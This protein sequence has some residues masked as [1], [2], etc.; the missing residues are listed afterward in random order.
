MSRDVTVLSSRDEFVATVAVAA[1]NV[2]A[3]AIAGLG[4]AHVA[5]TGGTIG[6]AVLTALGHNSD[7]DWRKVHFWWGDERFV[8]ASSLERNAVQARDAL[9]SRLNL[10]ESQIHEIPASDS[11]L[12]LDNAA[13]AYAE[14]LAHY[15]V[16]GQAL[17]DF[18]LTFLGIGPDSHVASLFPDHVDALKP[19]I[20]VPVRNSPKP[21]SERV[22]LTFNAINSS[23]RVWVVAFGA[24][25]AEA[26]A[27][28]FAGEGNLSAPS[29]CVHGTHETRLW[30]DMA[31]ASALSA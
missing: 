7:V 2:I 28:M 1:E 8:E 10:D 19:G 4:V 26:V 14:T 16:P 6:V 31:A 11:G 17:P 22:S 15:A 27:Q 24:D 30:A 25:K 3:Q 12:S 9:L 21:P 20:V 29:S 5:L 23:K 13:R 18:D